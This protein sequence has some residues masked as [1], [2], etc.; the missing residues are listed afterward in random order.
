VRCS[1]NFPESF[2][3]ALEILSKRWTG[4]VIFVL[5]RGP[6]RFNE[7]AAHIDV[8]SDRMLSE[9]LKELEAEGIVERRIFAEVPVRV[10]YRLTDKGA[11][12]GPIYESIGRWA[13]LWIDGLEDPGACPATDVP[14]HAEAASARPS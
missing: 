10:E 1:D 5:Q 4:L 8:I 9:R 3:R 7:I 11:A 13:A 14:A 2:Q 6:L 12:L